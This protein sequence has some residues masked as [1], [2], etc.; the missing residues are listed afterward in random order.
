MTKIPLLAILWLI[1][2]E[3][4]AQECDSRIF[5]DANR[6]GVRDEP[7]IGIA[8]VAVSDGERLVR[9]ES[10]GRYRLKAFPG[11][12]L[13]LIKPPGYS[14]PRR[15]DGLPDFFSNQASTV[16]GLAYGGVPKSDSACRSFALWNEADDSK[17]EESLSVLVFGDPQ[18]KSAIDI[19]YYRRD[20]VLPLIGKADAQLAISLGDIVHDDLALLPEIKSVDAILGLPWLY[21]AGNHD[22]DF[23]APDDSSSLESFRQQF[24]PDTF[25]WEES[26]A[27]FIILDDVVYLPGNR[28]DYIGGLRESQFAFLE[29]YLSNLDK[30]KLLVI[31]AH[32]PFFQTKSDRET[33]R[34]ADRKRLFALLAPFKDVLLLT[35]HSHTQT[36]VSHGPDTDWFGAG[37][38]YEYNAGATCGA[39]WS[40]VKDNTGIP[41]STMSD[42]TPNGYAR[43]NI[44]RNDYR[45]NWF[46]ARQ[47]PNQAMALHAP[48]VLR[49]GAY[50][51]FGVTANVFMARPDTEVLARIDK[52][53]WHKM[54]RVLKPDPL[55]LQ[56][57]AKDDQADT[58][59]SY[60]RAPAATSSSHLWYMPLPT[61]LET[62][63][64]QVSVRARDIWLGEV[65]VNTSYELLE[66]DP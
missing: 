54:Q 12:S 56:I 22:L 60:D 20:I 25:A 24:G 15:T 29:A 58:L 1:S 64:H 50:P 55:V 52:G 41:D 48:K 36:Q 32:I 9:S 46:N 44:S 6:N 31:A 34:S 16:N 10:D 3:L 39:F 37:R 53:P 57:N 30:T 2:T 45:L 63:T 8:G 19:D 11:K 33:F 59:R 62:G 18:P 40:G 17:S 49:K 27:N 5:L 7:E 13:F 28:P 23:D 21:A 61:D 51:G 47:D 66:A 65:E 14:L 42:G 35:A 43:L 4:Y 38:L 26:M